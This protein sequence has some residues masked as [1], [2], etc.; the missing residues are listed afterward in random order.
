MSIGTAGALVTLALLS[1]GSAVLVVVGSCCKFNRVH[2]GPWDWNSEDV[3][4]VV[5]LF[6]GPFL[7]WTVA[8]DDLMRGWR[9]FTTDWDPWETDNNASIPMPPSHP[10]A[11]CGPTGYQSDDLQQVSGSE[12]LVGHRVWR[13]F[14]DEDG[15][16]LVSTTRP[17]RYTGPIARADEE[18]LERGYGLFA[19]KPNHPFYE[20]VNPTY[21]V[22]G[23]VELFGKIVE[24]SKGYRATKLRITELTLRGGGWHDAG[25][26]ERKFCSCELAERPWLHPYDELIEALSERYRCEVSYEARPGGE[27]V[28]GKCNRT[29]SSRIG[30]Y[31]PST[32]PNQQVT[33]TRNELAKMKPIVNGSELSRESTDDL[34]QPADLLLEPD[35]EDVYRYGRSQP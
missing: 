14:E 9:Y 19:A 28:E 1:T 30:T 13:L 33:I 24:G 8:L 35:P 18:D 29:D 20:G 26:F 2:E 32:T 15:P 23:Q 34:L 21:V 7:S 3:A 10:F 11:R 27:V 16:V 22:E 31:L 25:R 12:V 17:H 5:A 6:V 4:L